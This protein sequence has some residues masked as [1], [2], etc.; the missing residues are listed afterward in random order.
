MTRGE[1]I[2]LAAGIAG[3]P[4]ESV[5]AFTLVVV[6]QRDEGCNC[7]HPENHRM[8]HVVS[9]EDDQLMA[10]GILAEGLTAVIGLEA[11]AKYGNAGR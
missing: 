8:P 10:C 5:V 1:V 3:V 2:T 6:V 9:T 11:E 7:G 4:P